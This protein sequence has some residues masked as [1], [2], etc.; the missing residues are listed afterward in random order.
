MFGILWCWFGVSIGVARQVF[1]VFFL[2]SHGFVVDLVR[3]VPNTD[4]D[5]SIVFRA[6]GEVR[7]GASY[8]KSCRAVS[9]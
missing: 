4:L 5:H 7:A 6:D 3:V 9:L 2:L 1:V 8:L